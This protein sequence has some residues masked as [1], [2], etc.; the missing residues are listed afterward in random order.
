MGIAQYA[1]KPKEFARTL[2]LEPVVREIIE[3]LLDRKYIVIPGARA[4]LRYQ[5]ARF[6]PAVLNKISDAIVRKALA[7]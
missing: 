6:I 1:A 3:Q 7:T 4:R 2:V 5:L